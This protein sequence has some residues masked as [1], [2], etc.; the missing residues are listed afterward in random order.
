[1]LPILQYTSRAQH[2]S[3]QLR[4]KERQFSSLSLDLWKIGGKI[5]MRRTEVSLFF[6]Y[7]SSFKIV[8]DI[9]IK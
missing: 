5:C 2:F 4:G 6:K 7:N 3:F 9:N 1:M 8:R